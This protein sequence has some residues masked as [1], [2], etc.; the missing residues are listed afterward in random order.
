VRSCAPTHIN[1]TEASYK[2]SCASQIAGPKKVG[3]QYPLLV[4]LTGA[5]MILY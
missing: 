3:A 2:F 5:R 4:S 1:R